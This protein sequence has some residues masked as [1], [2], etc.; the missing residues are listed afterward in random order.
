MAGAPQRAQQ[1]YVRTL[2]VR[3]RLLC[4]ATRL[5]AY[6]PPEMAARLQQ[7]PPELKAPMHPSQVAFA[8]QAET[9]PCNSLLPGH[10][11]VVSAGVGSAG[12]DSGAG[13]AA[14]AAEL[15]LRGREAERLAA[16]AEAAARAP[17][18]AA[19]AFARAAKRAV[20]G[21]STPARKGKTRKMRSYPVRQPGAPE[22]VTLESAAGRPCPQ[23]LVPGVCPRALDAGVGRMGRQ[24]SRAAVRAAKRAAKRA[25][26]RASAPAGTGT[27]CEMRSYPMQP[28]APLA[29][30]T[31][32]PAAGRPC[33][34]AL[35]PRACP[36]GQRLGRAAARGKACGTRPLGP[37]REWHNVRNAQLPR[38]TSC[39]ITP[40]RRSALPIAGAT[41]RGNVRHASA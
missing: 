32:E 6:L 11:P 39:H 22:P 2:V 13:R 37:S 1:R 4:A 34:Q 35:D 15:A 41:T 10:E 16:R 24:L 40:R 23:A 7:G 19:I 33:P 25:A 5:R 27:T 28:P 36:M 3:T 18:K 38:A 12:R 17:W 29:P 26:R 9:T 20:R 21:A 31:A 14:V 8:R 30:V